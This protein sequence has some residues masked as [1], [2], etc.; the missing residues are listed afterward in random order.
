MQKTTVSRITT[1]AKVFGTLCGN[2]VILTQTILSERYV[3]LTKR[4][5]VEIFFIWGRPL[6]LRRSCE[7]VVKNKTYLMYFNRLCEV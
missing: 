5:K 3:L 2:F 6:G 1:P 4:R 7:I